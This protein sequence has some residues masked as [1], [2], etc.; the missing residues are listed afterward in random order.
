MIALS[1]VEGRY[2]DCYTVKE[3]QVTLG[4]IGLYVVFVQGSIGQVRRGICQTCK[5]CESYKLGHKP[6]RAPLRQQLVGAPL[7]RVACDIVGPVT[8]S[9][10]GN[11]YILVV[12]DYFTKFVEA[13]ILPDQTARAVADTTGETMG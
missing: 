11:I 12:A 7:E 8:T 5:V 2:S 13:Y 1:L 6:K 9:K 10:D 4:F 3:L